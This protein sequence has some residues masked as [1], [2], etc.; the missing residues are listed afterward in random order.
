MAW[1]RVVTLSLSLV[2]GATLHAS[3]RDLGN[4]GEV[5]PIA[6]PDL[7]ALIK[8]KISALIADGGMERLT[9]EMQDKARGYAN[10]PKGLDLP[11]ATEDRSFTLDL[12]IRVDYDLADQN[13]VV[14]AA[15]GTVVNP[16]A[17][18]GFDKTILFIDGDDLDQVAWAI[19][20]GDELDSLIVLTQGAPL[21]LSKTWGR[22]FWFDQSGILT[23]RFQIARL[24]SRVTR[25]DPVMRIDEVAL[26]E[27][28]SSSE[29]PAP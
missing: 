24:P 11:R 13:G 3:A 7:L 25:A 5:F 2:L 21:D 14:F 23:N 28:G 9:T 29:V 10:R 26:P 16:L 27:N 15:A 1:T 20:Q 19:S 12:S 22:R 6:E 8:G 17:W 18:S 4:F